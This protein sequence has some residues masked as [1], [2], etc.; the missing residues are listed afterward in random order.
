MMKFGLIFR[1]VG[2]MNFR[3]YILHSNYSREI[4]SAWCLI[5]GCLNFSATLKNILGM[6]LVR[7]WCADMPYCTETEVRNQTSYLARSQCTDTGPTSHDT[8][9]VVSGT[10]QGRH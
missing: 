4:T 6:D 1:Q 3:N 10:G 9:T 2:L 5:N 8:D 7:Q